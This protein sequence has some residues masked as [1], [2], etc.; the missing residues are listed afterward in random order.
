MKRKKEKEETREE[1]EHDE[2]E[3]I[4][5]NDEEKIERKEYLRRE[6]KSEQ[7]KRERN[8][9]MIQKEDN[10]INHLFILSQTFGSLNDLQV[11]LGASFE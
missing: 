4:E 6:S 10:Q 3:N 9:I 8:Q 1:C 11:E 2:S 7:E 5:R